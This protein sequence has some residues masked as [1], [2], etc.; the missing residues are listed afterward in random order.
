MDAV[1]WERGYRT[2]G[3]WDDHCTRYAV[4]GLGPRCN[5]DGIYRWWTDADP[6]DVREAKTLKAAKRAAYLA[7]VGRNQITTKEAEE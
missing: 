7:V 6:N 2:H 5:W 1:H 3:L 4:V